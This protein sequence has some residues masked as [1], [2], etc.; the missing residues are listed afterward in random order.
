M[1]RGIANSGGF[2]VVLVALL[3]FRFE[4]RAGEALGTRLP[5]EKG[6]ETVWAQEGLKEMPVPRKR[7]AKSFYRNVQGKGPCIAFTFDDGPRPWTAD[8]LDALKER[9]LKGTFF[10]TGT[11]AQRYAS[12]V[13]RMIAEGH[14][15][16]N[17]TL[18]HRDNYLHRAPH[19]RVEREVRGGHEAIAKVAGVAP[20]V[21]RPP[22]GNFTEEQTAWI[23]DTFGY[24]N[25]NWSVDP[26]D[27]NTVK[28]SPETFKRRVLGQV[29]NG[30]I[31]LSHD[32]HQSTVA[33]IPATLDALMERGYQFLTVSELLALDD[34]YEVVRF[35]QSEL[36]WLGK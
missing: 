19:S 21:F 16:A 32:L 35:T 10:V 22:G 7:P 18:T 24:A 4:G 8:V 28:P 31:I 1:R 34:P 33:A 30:A 25:I 26:G 36:D 6:E 15:V 13:R 17:H 2:L 9:N 20:R 3:P 29:Y 27:G 5:W 14:E 23:Y 12:L 11:E